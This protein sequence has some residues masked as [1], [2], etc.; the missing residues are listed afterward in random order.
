MLV[1]DHAVVRQ[2]VKSFLSLQP[3]MIIVGEAESGEEAVALVTEL[4]PDVVLMDLIMP[5]GISGIEATRRIKDVS[6]NTQIVVLT[7]YHE[8][9]YIFAAMR[10]GALSYILK[11][12]EATDL[13]DSVREAALHHARLS[14]YIATRV[15]MDFNPDLPNKEE[16]FCTLTSREMEVLHL[17][18]NGYENA[19]ISKKLFI[20][21]KTVRAHMSNI[22]SK[23]HLKDR[24]QAA[25]YAWREGIVHKTNNQTG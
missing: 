3:D 22:L 18:A 1:D 13:A 5:H 12:V 23:L 24:T 2:G 8:D 9:E 10:A 20:N 4:I 6:P 25:V 21:I 7:S 19:L 15:M 17:V 14:P 11:N 16:S